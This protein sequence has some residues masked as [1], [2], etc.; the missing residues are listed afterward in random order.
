[1]E[2]DTVFK[3]SARSES[4]KVAGAIC[5]SLRE[6]KARVTLQAIGAGAINQATKSLIIARSYLAS[7]QSDICW[8]ASFYDV[9]IEND[10]HTAV[11]FDVSFKQ[12]SLPPLYVTHNDFH[13]IGA[14][15]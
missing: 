11:R 2:Q 4:G 15:T 6:G 8:N 1:M 5:K 9:T 7:E 14:P 10:G 12:E 13:K 3:V